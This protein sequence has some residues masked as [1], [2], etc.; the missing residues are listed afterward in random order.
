MII[1]IRNGNGEALAAERAGMVVSRFQAKAAMLEAGILEKVE[2]IV[3]QGDQVFRL[4]W[5][6]ATEFR[7]TSAAINSL[8]EASGLTQEDLDELFRAAAKIE[9]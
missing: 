2:A 1:K 4:A 7:R 9:V 6:E 3:E 8:G 5:S